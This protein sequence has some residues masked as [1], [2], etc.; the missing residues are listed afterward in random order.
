VIGPDGAFWTGWMASYGKYGGGVTRV[1]PATL[2]TKV[3]TD[4]AG[5]QCLRW[6]TAGDRFV[7]FATYGAGNGLPSQTGPFHLVAW[8]PEGAEVAR[9]TFPENTYASVLEWH[10]GRLLMAYRRALEILDDGTLETLLRIETPNGV[11]AMA[12][13]R[14][15]LAVVVWGSVLHLV[16]VRDGSVSYE[17]PI[18]PGRVE[19]VAVTPDGKIYFAIGTLLYV[20]EGPSK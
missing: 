12:P 1:D 4:P 8:T 15:A 9:R 17:E 19:T 18:P 11:A 13:Y 16:D 14:D 2:E 5:A 7:Y 10:A 20:A 6:I 3:W